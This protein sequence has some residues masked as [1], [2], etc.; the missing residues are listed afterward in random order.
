MMKAFDTRLS[1]QVKADDI[2]A[3][4]VMHLSKL[5]TEHRTEVPQRWE[6]HLQRLWAVGRNLTSTIKTT[7]PPNEDEAIDSHSL[8]IFQ[9]LAEFRGKSD[10][11]REEKELL[12]SPKTKRKGSSKKKRTSLTALPISPRKHREEIELRDEENPDLPH[13]EREPHDPAETRRTASNEKK[14]RSITSR[15]V[16]PQKKR[17]EREMRDDTDADKDEG[18]REDRNDQERTRV[19]Q[20]RS[21]SGSSSPTSSSGTHPR[22]TTSRNQSHRRREDPEP[23]DSPSSDSSSGSSLHDD[24]PDDGSR[25]GSPK[26]TNARRPPK[27]GKFD[28]IVELNTTMAKAINEMAFQGKE[29]RADEKKKTSLLSSWTT[30]A[31]GLLKLLS[32]NDWREKGTPEVNDFMLE[33]T[34]EKKPQRAI[35]LIEEEA[36][37]NRWAGMATTNGLTEFFVRG[38]SAP[39]FMDSP[40]GFTVFMCKPREHLDERTDW[41]K[42]Q[43]LQDLFGSG[44]LSDETLKSFIKKDWFLP[45]DR[46]ECEDQL[47]VAIQLLDLMTAKDGIGSAG[48]RYG[49]QLIK[50]NR[51]MFSR[52]TQNDK[53]FLWKFLHLLDS[54][55]QRFC[56]KMREYIKFQDP[57]RE[58]RDG[59]MS[60]LQERLIDRGM[61]AFFDLGHSPSLPL[62]QALEKHSKIK[63]KK[64]SGPVEIEP[65][66][67]GKKK[68]KV[69]PA[70]RD[71]S[72]TDDPW[73][74]NPSPVSEW[75][76]PGS[77]NFA[78]LFGRG[79]VE[80]Q[81]GFPL[82]KHHIQSGKTMICL[83]YQTRSSCLR[84][85][86]CTMS[87][88]NPKDMASADF[89][90]MSKRFK[91]IYKQ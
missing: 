34:R 90:T 26:S 77:Q 12:Y 31:L 85:A 40:G 7:P 14:K 81:S 5:G 53:Y 61:G 45:K 70:T 19:H 13:K 66:A 9:R 43:R 59:G 32:G 30:K 27:R 63:P 29:R 60:T 44:D 16:S 75:A 71:Q 17:E 65:V 10:R 88:I 69:T 25:K 1:G 38:F 37:E 78:K 54:A 21:P 82:A 58:A 84:G 46:S 51:V 89:E 87:H 91:E 62:P 72:Q 36:M 48:Y 64:T 28:M 35:T 49:L 3:S 83:S 56:E 8:D 22:S 33:A 42:K 11:S 74:K 52:E 73:A 80:N 23:S 15:S 86:K 4:L 50:E 41:E 67:E 57:L 20:E 76:I 39:D 2:A 6:T 68:K 47:E 79:M 18:D 55:F 24:L